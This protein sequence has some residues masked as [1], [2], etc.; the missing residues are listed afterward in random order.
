MSS[1]SA[2]RAAAPSPARIAAS[3]AR[4]AV[5]DVSSETQ[6]DAMFVELKAR[7]GALDVLVNNAGIAG[8]TATV[9]DP[10][11]AD[12]DQTNSVNLTRPFLCTCRAVP[13]LKAAGGSASKYGVIGLTETWAMERGPDHIRVN[14]ILSGIVAGDRQERVIAAKAAS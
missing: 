3:T 5:T 12:W 6:V 4:C 1:A 9:E 14:I 11:L 8:L 13:L 10:A 2:V 7:W